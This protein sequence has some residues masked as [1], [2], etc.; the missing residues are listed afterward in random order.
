LLC[1]GKIYWELYD[2]QQKDQRKD[3]AIIWVEQLHPFPKKQIEAHL[4]QYKKAEVVWVQEE[5]ENMGYWSFILREFPEIGLGSVIAR[6]ASAS[7]ATGYMKIHT[8]EQAD[9]I[10]QAFAGK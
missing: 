10:E 5:P 3:V 7:P 1:T 2:K 9:L 8:V 4:A 6:K